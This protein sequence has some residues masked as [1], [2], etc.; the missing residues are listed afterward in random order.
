MPHDAPIVRF[1][2]GR[3]GTISAQMASRVG[4]RG[5]LDASRSEV[6]IMNLIVRKIHHLDAQACV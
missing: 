4:G 1:V 6:S 5:G 2:S 3:E